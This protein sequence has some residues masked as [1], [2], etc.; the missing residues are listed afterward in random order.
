MKHNM[1]LNG[2]S[3]MFWGL[4]FALICFARYVASTGGP[5]LVRVFLALTAAYSIVDIGYGIW[6]ARKAVL[7][8]KA[9]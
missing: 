6:A 2:I 3:A 9:G 7:R 8:S 5:T 1:I 4:T